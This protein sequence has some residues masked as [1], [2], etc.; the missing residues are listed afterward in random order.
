MA[1]KIEPSSPFWS[2]K[3]GN[4]TPFEPSEIKCLLKMASWRPRAS[5]SEPLGSILEAFGF[6]FE[7]LECSKT[8]FERP[9]TYLCL[10]FERPVDPTFGV[11]C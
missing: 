9:W 2:Q 3:A 5:N 6:D 4:G 7:V 11:T 8:G 10:F 1:S